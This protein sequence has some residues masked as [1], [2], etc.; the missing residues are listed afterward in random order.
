MAGS[1]SFGPFGSPDGAFSRGFG[2]RGE[3]H[4]ADEVHLRA[5]YMAPGLGRFTAPDPLDGVDGT[6]TVANAY[7]YTMNNPIA[8]AD[9]LGL[10][11]TDDT[12]SNAH[13]KKRGSFDGVKTRGAASRSSSACKL[14]PRL[15]GNA[16][17][18]PRPTREQYLTAYPH[19]IICSGPWID[20]DPS[21]PGIF[22]AGIAVSKIPRLDGGLDCHLLEEALVSRVASL[23]K[24]YADL[25]AN[26]GNQ[27]RFGQTMSVESHIDHYDEERRQLRRVIDYGKKHNC[28]ERYPYLES[29]MDIAERWVNTLDPIN[30]PATN[31]DFGRLV[32]VADF[33]Y[34]RFEVRFDSATQTAAVGAAALLVVLVIGRVLLDPFGI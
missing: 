28:L 8:F 10:R 34:P 24:R 21:V 32:D 22:V 4:V 19:G 5:R 16:G 20:F 18:G 9:P 7:H 1:A 13:S 6:T 3:L 14:S 15:P 25:V 29:V 17:S 23:I 30:N 11:P 2:F 12:F 27:P 31:V 26:P 33:E